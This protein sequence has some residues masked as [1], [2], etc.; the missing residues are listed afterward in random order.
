MSHKHTKG[1]PYCQN[2]HYPI[3]EL[4][5]FCP[6]CG[7]QNTDGHVSLHDLWHEVSHYFTHVDNKI[8]VT[9]RHLFVPGKLTEA[10]FKGHR[11]R[12]IHPIN[13]FFLLGVILPFVFGQTWKDTAKKN[14]LDKGFIQDK[15][16]YHNDLL[17]ELD[18]TV[19]HDTNRFDKGTR[20]VLDSFLRENYRRKNT[21]LSTADTSERGYQT[22]YFLLTDKLQ[23]TRK[24]MSLLN[25]TLQIDGNQMDK[26]LMRRRLDEY[27]TYFKKLQY[28]SITI[29]VAFA[30]L[31]NVPL[32]EV[33]TRIDAGLLGYSFGK[34]LATKNKKPKPLDIDSIMRYPV[35]YDPIKVRLDSI[36]NVIKRDSVNIGMLMSK[37]IK[38]D[39]IDLATMDESEIIDKYHI[40]GWKAQMLLKQTKRFGKQGLEAIMKA[41]SDKSV[42]YTI[43]TIVT[44]AWFLLLMY[45]SQHKL[46]VEHVV[47]LIHYNCFSF[48]TS[49]L[50]L[51][52]KDWLLYAIIFL[53]FIFLIF[54]I[55]RFYKQSWGKS[56]I[57]SILYYL[58]NV[59]FSMIITVIGMILSVLLT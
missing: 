3:A 1:L 31:K 41:Y 52:H 5:K 50:M 53:G 37:E 14:G 59:I 7:Q 12:Y 18:S 28:D 15:A 22:Q 33:K 16:L 55:K 24:A 49:A 17:F 47:F 34:S 58:V 44:S 19:K 26:P 25:D 11:K 51:F 45:R 43:F 13:L 56:I 57:K 2:C 54:A 48:V 4:D 39:E 46:Y 21:K 6:N 30:K 9:L 8:F 35:G 29:L 38:I 36:R 27:E 42:W 20:L 32:T 23:D 40:E 10:F